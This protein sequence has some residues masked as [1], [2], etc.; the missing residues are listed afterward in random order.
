M[1]DIGEAQGNIQPYRKQEG[2]LQRELWALMLT[3]ISFHLP[4]L[5]V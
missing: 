1:Q 4:I 3:N 5:S 2:N